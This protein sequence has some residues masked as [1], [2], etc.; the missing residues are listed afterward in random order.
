MTSHDG[1]HDRHGKEVH[2]PCSS[3]ISSIEKSNGNSIEFSL[4]IAEQRAVGFILAWS[5]A[6]LQF[7][8]AIFVTNF[9]WPYLHQFFDDSHGLKSYRKPSKRPFDQC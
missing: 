5:L 8:D 3:C 1:S 7:N 2:R 4:S 9:I 6:T